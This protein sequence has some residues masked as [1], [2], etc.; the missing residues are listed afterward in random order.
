METVFKNAKVRSK[1]QL[2][3]QRTKI[4][5]CMCRNNVVKPA[6]IYGQEKYCAV[7]AF[8][9]D[10]QQTISSIENAM[11]AAFEQNR[12]KLIENGKELA[13]EEVVKPIGD[14]MLR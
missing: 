10:D 1:S 9:M 7:I 3:A 11:R 14:G 6:H 5:G 2:Q 13:Y 8:P 4:D 12:K